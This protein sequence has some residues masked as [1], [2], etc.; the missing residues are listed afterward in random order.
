MIEV[1]IAQHM[2]QHQV[3][4][5]QPHKKKLNFINEKFSL[6]KAYKPSENYL[7]LL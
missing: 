2:R 5:L 3:F 6:M 7:T 1:P 4:S